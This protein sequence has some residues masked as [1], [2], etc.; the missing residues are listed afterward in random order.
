MPTG[1]ANHPL[2]LAIFNRAF[3]LIMFVIYML[4]HLAVTF[5]AGARRHDRSLSYSI[6]GFS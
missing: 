4:A 3:V 2:I 6:I 1:L 5:E